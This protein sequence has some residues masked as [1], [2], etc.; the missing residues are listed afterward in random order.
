MFKKVAAS[1]RRYRNV[2]WLDR[3]ACLHLS[4]AAYLL[5]AQ[6]VRQRLLQLLLLSW[7]CIDRLQL[8]AIVHA[9]DQSLNPLLPFRKM[10]RYYMARGWS[11]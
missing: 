10:V 1:S 7:S 3:A 9:E 2:G 6:G 5:R 11:A 8:P 4:G